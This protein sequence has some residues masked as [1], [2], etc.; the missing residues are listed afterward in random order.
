VRAFVVASMTLPN[1]LDRL[2]EGA[3]V[4]TA[5]DRADVI[6]GVSW[7]LWQSLRSWMTL[8]PTRNTRPPWRFSAV[9]ARQCVREQYG[10]TKR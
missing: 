5:G 1:L 3:T 4:I 6:L 7:P 10:Q 2:T 8:S 9:R